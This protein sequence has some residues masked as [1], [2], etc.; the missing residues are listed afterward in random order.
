[1]KVKGPGA[2]KETGKTKA[3]PQANQA[4]VGAFG[5]L[6]AAQDTP[7]QAASVGNAQSIAQMDALLAV[8]GAQDP[9]Q[10]RAR[11]RMKQRSLKVLDALEEIRLKMLGGRLTVGDMINVADVVATHREKITDPL[12]TG[13]MDEVDLRAQVELAKMRVELDKR[14][15]S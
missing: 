7:E 12:L 9:T 11:S 10:G 3:K 8:Q 6:M 13:L 5:A 14:K 4:D 1:M 2:S 15:A